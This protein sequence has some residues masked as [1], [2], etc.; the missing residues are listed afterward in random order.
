MKNIIKVVLSKAVLSCVVLMTLSQN[1]LS[2]PE[3]IEFWDARNDQ[4][5][6]VVDHSAWQALLNTYLDDQHKSGINRF[7]YK[8]VTKEDSKKLGWCS[9]R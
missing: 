6:V 9:G 8:A 7:D 4:S 3:K 1:A 2:A 5:E